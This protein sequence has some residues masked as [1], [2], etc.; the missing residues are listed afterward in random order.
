MKDWFK[1]HKNEI[2][3][4][5]ITTIICSIIFSIWQ[6]IRQGLPIAGNAIFRTLVNLIYMRAAFQNSGS[7]SLLLLILL[8]GL[9]L[10]MILFFAIRLWR[11]KVSGKKL[12]SI[13]TQIEELAKDEMFSK[14][15]VDEKAALIHNLLNPTKKRVKWRRILRIIGIVF[16]VLYLLIM[17]I[18]MVFPVMLWN[19]FEV[20]TIQIKPYISETEMDILK[21]KWTLMRCKEDFDEINSY[22]L[23]KRQ[24]NGLLN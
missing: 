9:L 13:Q 1:N 24:D 15:N 18:M 20:S 11:L 12:E 19:S 3:T 21:S 7:S 17:C 23:R 5:I 14:R 16:M 10:G 22:I 4:G 2:L 6:Y 8:L